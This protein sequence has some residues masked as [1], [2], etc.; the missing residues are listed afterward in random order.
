MNQVGITSQWL[1][2]YSELRSHQGENVQEITLI[3]KATRVPITVGL[4][5]AYHSSQENLPFQS[6]LVLQLCRIATARFSF[7]NWLTQIGLTLDLTQSYQ[8]LSSLCYRKFATC[9]G[10]RLS[11]SNYSD[12]SYFPQAKWTFPSVQHNE[13]LRFTSVYFV[14]IVVVLGWCAGYFCTVLIGC[15]MMPSDGI[16]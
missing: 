6:F 9:S 2:G 11:S 16:V 1:A 15:G 13:T 8:L 14:E 4:R 10:K 7:C 5:L 12:L 3:A